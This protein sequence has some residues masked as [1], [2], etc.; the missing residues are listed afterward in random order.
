MGSVVIRACRFFGSVKLKFVNN[1]ISLLDAL[2]NIQNYYIK[3]FHYF[4]R[5]YNILNK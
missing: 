4:I 3:E 5:K 1:C 2:K